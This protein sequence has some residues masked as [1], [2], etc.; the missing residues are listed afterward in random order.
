MSFPFIDPSTFPKKGKCST[1]GMAFNHGVGDAAITGMLT[2]ALWT[3]KGSIIGMLSHY[4][5]LLDNPNVPAQPQFQMA[6]S[7][8][9]LNVCFNLESGMLL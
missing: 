7:R 2:G 8:T 3:I 1:G 4:F 9:H 6:I 5:R